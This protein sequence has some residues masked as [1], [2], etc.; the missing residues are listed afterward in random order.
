MV[1][2]VCQLSSMNELTPTGADACIICFSVAEPSS[3]KHVQS[4]LQDFVERVDMASE[5]DDLCFVAVGTKSDLPSAVPVETVLQQLND[6]LPGSQLAAQQRRREASTE[7]T[8]SSSSTLKVNKPEPQPVQSSSSSSNNTSRSRRSSQSAA[9]LSSRTRKISSTSSSNFSDS[10]YHTP[11]GSISTMTPDSFRSSSLST[12]RARS[13]SSASGGS[14]ASSSTYRAAARTEATAEVGQATEDRAAPPPTEA[15]ASSS[16]EHQPLEDQIATAFTL[17]YTSSK[18]GEAVAD[19]FNHIATQLALRLAEKRRDQEWARVD[20]DELEQV[21]MT[22]TLRNVTSR[23]HI[24]LDHHDDY[25]ILP[26]K[27]GT[28]EDSKTGWTCC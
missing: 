22:F 20:D 2:V 1:P 6:L 5:I 25:S 16:S 18:T 4:W 26:L 23:N 21:G 11:A 24:M 15:E 10:I 7:S 3:L 8:E 9:L 13:D 19:P 27:S 12:I 14:A 17:F 28:A